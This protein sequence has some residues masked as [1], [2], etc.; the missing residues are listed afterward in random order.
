MRS[1][2][3]AVCH[4]R[5]DAWADAVQARLL[6]VHDLHAVDAVYHITCHGN[7]RTKKQIPVVHE[8]NSKRAKPGRPQDK[9]RTDA[10]LE[11]ASFLEEND[12]E[13]I[14]IQD[15]IERMEDN[16]ADSEHD[17]YSYKY[18]QQK[19]Q[20]YFGGQMIQT[21]INGIG[22]MWSPSEPRPVLCFRTS[23]VIRKLILAQTRLGWLRLLLN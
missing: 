3:L 4:E 14:T 10:F 20:E 1:T 22:P 15:L 18:I 12:D 17:A 9:E 21:K 7:F 23:T 19:V 13:Q 11:V 16:L 6:Q 8:I 5:G 2:I